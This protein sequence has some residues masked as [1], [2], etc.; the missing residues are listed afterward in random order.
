MAKRKKWPKITPV[1][2]RWVDST[3]TSGWNVKPTAKMECVTVGNL[4]TRNKRRV[5]IALNKSCYGDGEIMEIPTVAVKD[6]RRLKRG[7]R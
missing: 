7:K 6:I 1:V 5:A 4:L 2:V 3:S